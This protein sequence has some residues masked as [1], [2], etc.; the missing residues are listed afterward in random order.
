MTVRKLENGKNMR[1]EL[2]SSFKLTPRNAN[3]DPLANTAGITTVK[4]EVT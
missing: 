3:T 1:I 4:L 2:K